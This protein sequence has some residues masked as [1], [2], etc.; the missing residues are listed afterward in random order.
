MNT[1]AYVFDKKM[2]EVI[3][4][5]HIEGPCILQVGI[6]HQVNNSTVEG[7]WTLCFVLRR[8]TDNSYI[9]F[10]ETRELFKSFT[11]ESL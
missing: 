1:P 3:H 9:P 4:S 5:Q 8:K 10:D 6:P 7:R 2:M 11:K